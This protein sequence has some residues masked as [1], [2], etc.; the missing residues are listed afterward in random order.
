VAQNRLS[1]QT[2]TQGTATSNLAVDGNLNQ[3]RTLLCAPGLTLIMNAL[4]CICRCLGHR[5]RSLMPARLLWL[6]R[7]LTSCHLST[8]R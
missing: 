5:V 7:P 1:T 2:S 3:V 8:G 4:E 6:P